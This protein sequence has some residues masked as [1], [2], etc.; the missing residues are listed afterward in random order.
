M[1][2]PLEGF[3]YTVFITDVFSWKVVG[4]GVSSTMHTLGIPVMVLKQALFEAKKSG[5]DLRQ[6]V[7]QTD[8]WVPVY[9]W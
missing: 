7:H 4:W 8:T 5:S 3:C 6:I 9:C 1:S 2:E